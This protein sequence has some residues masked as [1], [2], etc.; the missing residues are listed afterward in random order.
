MARLQPIERNITQEELKLVHQNFD[1]NTIDNN[2]IVQS[3]E[4]LGYVIEAKKKLAGCSSGLAYMHEKDYTGWFYLSDLIVFNPYRKQGYGRMLLTSLEEKLNRL[5]IHKI[6]T[7]TA[8][9]EAPGFYKKMGYVE[10][11]SMEKWYSDGSPRVG[12]TKH[13][14]AADTSDLP[15]QS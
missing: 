7:W 12:F 1:L 8:G 13:L 14:N 15:I 10:F 3:A 6:Y 2:V 4:R 5:G 11:A 9:Y